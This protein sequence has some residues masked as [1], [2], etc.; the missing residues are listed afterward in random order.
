MEQKG[1]F[2]GQGCKIICCNPSFLL[3]LLTEPF[4]IRTTEREFT[5]VVFVDVYFFQTLC[6]CKNIFQTLFC[7]YSW[8]LPIASLEGWIHYIGSSYKSWVD[9]FG[10]IIETALVCGWKW[11][12][13]VVG[14]WRWLP[15]DV[16]GMRMPP[17]P[18]ERSSSVM[19]TT[20]L[21]TG[22]TGH[23]G[24][25]AHFARHLFCHRSALPTPKKSGESIRI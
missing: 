7:K 4:S 13:R 14:G 10:E 2:C 12:V 17:T 6:C 5:K 19:P 23:H 9:I 11:D 22:S 20:S 1:F 8:Q 16:P 3:Y 15:L 24:E 21:T 25:V 18:P